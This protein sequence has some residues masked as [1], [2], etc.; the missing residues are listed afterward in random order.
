V[1]PPIVR[2]VNPIRID[3]LT[4]V[5]QIR[6]VDTY[7]H[8]SVFVVAA[9]MLA[10]VRSRPALTIVGLVSYLSV[11]LIHEIGHLIAAQRL[12]CKVNFIK[13]YPVFGITN[14]EIP[15]TRLD[16]CV[17]AWSGVLAQ[18]VVAIPLVAWVSV[19]GYSRI[20]AINA[21]FAIL[22]FFSLGVAVFN[23]LP[24][25]PLD[26]AT[27]WGLLPALLARKRTL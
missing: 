9:L 3:K 26:G 19:F 27:A 5:V 13:L 6:G 21:V 24:F 11:I 7:V 15:W 14:F 20:D 23:L 25:P 16:R 2:F 1:R 8:W 12:G 22:G 10:N 18:A 17:I 4:K